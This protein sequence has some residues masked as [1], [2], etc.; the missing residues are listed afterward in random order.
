VS[1]AITVGAL[2][3]GASLYSSNKAAGAAQ[4]ASSA[5]LQGT[6]ES[7][8]LQRSMYDQSVQR[9]QPWLD[10][11]RGALGQVQNRLLSPEWNQAF[12]MEQFQQDPGY[13]FRQQEGE[14][15]MQRRFSAGGRLFSGG[16][17]KDFAGYNSGLASQEFGNAFNR[18]QTDRQARLNPLMQMAGLGQG[19]AQQV[20]QQGMQMASQIGQNTMAG[21]DASAAGIMGA[22]NA[23]TA[24][25]NNLYGFLQKKPW[26]MKPWESG[27]TT[28]G[29]AIDT[30]G[31]W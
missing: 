27:S 7:N 12:G 18:F 21:A 3:V 9:Q 5:Q 13:Q 2:G 4:D 25:M 8:D 24:G 28:G 31:Y 22:N 10:A 6:R 16:A 17:I 15:A 23:R 14:K 20:G 1:F 11:G 26:E 19:S 29:Q 30:G